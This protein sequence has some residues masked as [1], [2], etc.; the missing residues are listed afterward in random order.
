MEPVHNRMKLVET[1]FDQAL[2][3]KLSQWAR[4]YAPT[5]VFKLWIQKLKKM[6]GREYFKGWKWTPDMTVRETIRSLED[7]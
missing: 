3:R 1:L 6:G 7:Y 5:P 4:G 2:K